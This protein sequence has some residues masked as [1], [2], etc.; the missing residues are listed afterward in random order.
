MGLFKNLSTTKLRGVSN[1]VKYG[2]YLVRIDKVK[3]QPGRLNEQRIFIEYTV[4][5]TLP[6]SEGPPNHVVGEEAC[7]MIE[8]TGNEYAAEDWARF[9]TGMFD[10]KVEELDSPDV[11]TLCGNRDTDDW[12]TNEDPKLGAVQPMRGMVAELKAKCIMTKEKPGNPS[13]PFTKIT[14]WR[15]ASKEEVVKA[16]TPELIARFFPGDSLK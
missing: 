6:H 8:I 16:L 12:A 2:N 14:G 7:Q 3:N 9:M 11:K 10:C 1:F 4:I 13:H 5:A 15:T